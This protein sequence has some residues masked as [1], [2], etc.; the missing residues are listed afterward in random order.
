MW[1]GPPP[2]NKV[3]RKGTCPDAKYLPETISVPLNTII[4]RGNLIASGRLDEAAR[5]EMMAR[6]LITTKA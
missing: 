3:V 6:C 1:R 2:V 4:A 5:K